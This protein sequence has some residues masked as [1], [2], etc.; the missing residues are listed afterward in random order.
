MNSNNIK[1]SFFRSKMTFILFVFICL[2]NSVH[3][4]LT[5]EIGKSDYP[6]LLNLP[7]D[8]ILKT[9]P[10]VL[11]FLHG[12][13]LSGNNLD[14]VK[15]Y[16]IINEILNGRKIPAIVIAP[17]VMMGKSW[18]PD[19]ILHVLQYVQ[20]LY[21]T[22]TA[23]VYVAGMSLGGYGT[24]HFAGKYPELVAGAVALCG[25]G[26]EKDACNLAQ[27]PL[28]IEH[29]VHDKAVAIGESDK[30]VRA[31]RKCNEGE[32]LIFIRNPT[33]SHGSLEKIFHS[34]IFYQWLFGQV[35]NKFPRE[36]TVLQESIPIVE[37]KE[38]L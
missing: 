30:I 29:G 34:D 18:E 8:S 5:A 17:Q 23:R 12:R 24:L 25:G 19:K 2:T 6:F 21:N 36:T 11:I 7:V 1:A 10:P 4:Q 15:R 31:I 13:S 37:E 22:D 14:I 26:N 27:I 20:S 16:G 33:A 38:Q 32:N 28:W 9:K 35:K 3:S